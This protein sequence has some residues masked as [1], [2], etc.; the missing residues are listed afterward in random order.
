MDRI[1][2]IG[3]H[4]DDETLGL[5]G[6][7]AKKS[8]SGDSVFVLIFTDGEIAR[9]VNKS[10]ISQRKAQLIDATK[11]LGVKQINFLNYNDQELDSIPLI[12]LSREIENAIKKWNPNV[13]YTH[14]YGDVNQDHRAVFDATLIASRPTP[15]SNI[16]KLICYET[17]SSTEWGRQKFE[18]NFF[19]DISKFIKTKQNAFKKYT[20]EMEK[21]PHPRS[22]EAIFANSQKWGS[23]VGVNNAEAF[24]KIREI[25]K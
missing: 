11:I 6:T 14:F 15:K 9:K 25:S 22:L 5:G 7:I 16:S 17:P 2:V 24:V 3:A 12:E 21:F 20:K 13:I 18:P 10:K 8:K 19:E 23:S 1:L 4:P